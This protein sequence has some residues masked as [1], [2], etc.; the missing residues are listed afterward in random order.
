MRILF[1]LVYLFLTMFLAASCDEDN[2]DSLSDYPNKTGTRW[3]YS[4]FSEFRNFQP[5]SLN[6]QLNL[7]DSSEVSIEIIGKMMFD[8][9]I[10]TYAFYGEEVFDFGVS[11]STNYY[12]IQNDG[13]YLYAYSATAGPVI[14][15]KPGSS[16]PVLF[17]GKIF[18]GIK[19][20][21]GSIT[22]LVPFSGTVADTIYIEDPP[23]KTLQFPMT[24]G[25]HWNFRTENSSW[26]IDKEVTGK[27]VIQ[28]I[29]G[30]FDCFVVQWLFDFDS[31]SVWDND[32]EYFDYIGE[33]GLIKRTILIKELALMNEN[34]EIIGT[35]DFYDEYILNN[36]YQ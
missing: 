15:P 3:T 7:R 30:S 22:D 34:S 27:K 6:D 10:E 26:V 2:S 12:Q 19:E 11:K 32:V 21:T 20:L 29:A 17:K 25:A 1:S 28:V 23:V 24:V 9:S 35:F 36:L 5:D 18:T 14:F 16:M 4:R 31:D 33:S 13:M 8:N